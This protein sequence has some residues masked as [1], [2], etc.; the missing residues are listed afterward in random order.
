MFLVGWGSAAVSSTQ[1]A[2]PL[3]AGA[4][5]VARGD[6]EVRGVLPPEGVIITDRRY[7]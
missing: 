6:I 7:Q 5:L 1:L 3:R 4:Q 2:I